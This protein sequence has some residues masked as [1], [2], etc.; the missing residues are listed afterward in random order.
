MI[1]AP[2]AN[3]NFRFAKNKGEFPPNGGNFLF[4]EISKQSE[5]IHLLTSPQAN[6]N[7][8]EARLTD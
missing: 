8:R 6:I 4:I 5:E 1:I 2:S 7:S 3:D